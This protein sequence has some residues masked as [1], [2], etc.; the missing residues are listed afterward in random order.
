MLALKDNVESISKSEY[1]E[2]WL[3]MVARMRRNRANM[4]KDDE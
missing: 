3:L 4:K 2:G 1:E